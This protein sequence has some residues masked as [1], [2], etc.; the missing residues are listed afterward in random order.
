MKQDIETI[1]QNIE[2]IVELYFKGYTLKRAIQM[3]KDKKKDEEVI[4]GA[5][6]FKKG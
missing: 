2:E 5:I 4:N 1:K 6:S 3:V